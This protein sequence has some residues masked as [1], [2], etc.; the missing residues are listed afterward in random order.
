MTDPNYLTSHQLASQWLSPARDNEREPG[1][2]YSL[3]TEQ[4]RARAERLCAELLQAAR[5]WRA[6]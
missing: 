2:V 5:C 3:L 4:E 6:A 1:R